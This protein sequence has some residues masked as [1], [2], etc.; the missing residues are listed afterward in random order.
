MKLIDEYIEIEDVAEL[1]LIGPK[2]RL[3]FFDIETTGLRARRSEVYLIGCLSFEKERGWRHRAW[4]SEAMEEECLI[5]GAFCDMLT[6]L[7]RRC[8]PHKPILV[9]YNGDGF[10]LPFISGCMRA[11]GLLDIREQVLSFDLYKELRS[12]KT[13]LGLTDMKLKTLERCL[14]IDRE[15]GYSGGEL[16]PLYMEYRQSRDEKL[17]SP[18]LLHNGEDIVNLPK[19]CRLLSYGQLFSGGFTLLSAGREELGDESFLDLRFE[20]SAELPKELLYEDGIYSISASGKQKRLLDIVV[21][22]YRGELKYF[23]ADHKNY[24][25][26][27]GEDRAIHKSVGQFVEKKARR[28]ATRETCY[29][30]Q[31]G[32]FLPEEDIV[33]APVYYESYKGKQLY[34]RFSEDLLSDEKKLCEYALSVLSH[35]HMKINAQSRV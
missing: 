10:D 24:Y 5:L 28:Q 30:R 31:D 7:R 12:L 22:L 11:Y 26:L 20:L 32:L 21:R 14:G 35:I 18:L 13:V 3:L 4:F 15:D 16:I 19:I 29:Q 25:Y 6:E 33:Y 9:T 8:S 2:E 1:S 27:P 23:Y 34:A 17:L